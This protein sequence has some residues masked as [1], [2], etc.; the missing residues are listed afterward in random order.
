MQTPTVTH[1]RTIVSI[2]PSALATV[3]LRDE[4]GLV[5]RTLRAILGDQGT[6][7]RAMSLTDRSKPLAPAKPGQVVGAA[8]AGAVA[9]DEVVWGY[10]VKEGF[11]EL[12][13]PWYHRGVTQH[14]YREGHD[15]ESLCGFR[16]PMSGPRERRR[17]RLG[18]PTAGIHPMCSACARRVGPPRPRVAVP[19]RPQQGAGSV[20]ADAAQHLSSGD[21]AKR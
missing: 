7:S 3:D 20:P 12:D 4:R 21:R 13:D 10:V 2:A 8:A 14:A 16:P 9:A 1:P 17:P 5:A 6:I 19:V 15:Q 18:L 11:D